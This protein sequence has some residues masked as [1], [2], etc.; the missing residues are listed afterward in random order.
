MS[1]TPAELAN[2]ARKLLLSRW[3]AFEDAA[4]QTMGESTLLTADLSRDIRA[5]VNASTKTYRYVLPTQVLAKACDPS[6][7]CRCIQVSRSGS[8]A[9]DAR[10]LAHGVIVPF[11]RT[12]ENV[13]GGSSEPYANNP[14]RVPE[15]SSAHRS[16]QRNKAGWDRLCRVLDA[17]EERQDP[18]FTLAVLDHILQAIRDR[19]EGASVAYAVPQRVSHT[20]LLPALQAYLAARS[21]GVRLQAIVAA[22][23]ETIGARFGVFAEVRS[24]KPTAADTSTGQVADLECCDS[25]GE[26][27][28][29]VEV[30]D[31]ELTLTQISDKTLLARGATVTELLFIAERG[32]RKTE[33]DA[34]SEALE[35]Q[36][37]SGHNVYVFQFEDFA[38]GLLALLGEAG[39]RQ[40]LTRV[41]DVLER[42]QAALSDRRAW[43]AA[44]RDL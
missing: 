44:L 30:K 43:A 38:S 36:F 39:R 5:S 4:A 11:D 8:G 25:S 13:L 17:I 34:V 24:R 15:I 14:V 16:A 23:F 20:R 22:L 10:S 33:H 41:G 26:I 1:L 27:A 40:F 18:G 35:H 12:N 7:D 21:G 9:F 31:R 29:A 6:L 3:L 42:Y 32:I 19:L 28:L 37:S 2:Q